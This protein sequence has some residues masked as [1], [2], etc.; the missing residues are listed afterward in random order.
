MRKA[1]LAVL[2]E[3]LDR[4]RSAGRSSDPQRVRRSDDEFNRRDADEK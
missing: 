1:E 4:V 3:V 2:D